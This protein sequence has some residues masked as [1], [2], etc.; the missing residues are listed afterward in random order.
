MAEREL[1]IFLI[2][3]AQ[4]REL[5][6][7]EGAA[8]RRR[9]DE[10]ESS[11]F[12]KA[13]LR[14]GESSISFKASLR[15]GKRLRERELK[16]SQSVA[17]PL[18]LRGEESSQCSL[19]RRW[20]PAERT[21]STNVFYSGIRFNEGATARRTRQQLC[22]CSSSGSGPGSGSQAQTYLDVLK[23]KLKLKLN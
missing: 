19:I 2:S 21:I 6:F 9:R 15:G 20:A 5:K 13:P 4:L 18:A 23:L 1:S 17:P 16:F 8:A 7:S 10:R 22:R 3:A 11:F 12:F 14:G